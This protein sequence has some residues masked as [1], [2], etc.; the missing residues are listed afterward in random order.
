MFGAGGEATAAYLLLYVAEDAMR[1]DELTATPISVSSTSNAN[2]SS[3]DVEQQQQQQQ[4]KAET[5]STIRQCFARV[6]SEFGIDSWLQRVVNEVTIAC[7][8]FCDSH[9]P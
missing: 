6:A 3:T 4:E 7:Y 5:I 2:S 9:L 1:D 8:A